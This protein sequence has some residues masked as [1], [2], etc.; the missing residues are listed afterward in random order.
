MRGA[1]AMTAT[2]LAVIGDVH[3]HTDHLNQVLERLEREPSLDGLL[4]VGDLGANLLHGRRVEPSRVVAYHQSVRDVLRRVE[5]FG[6]PFLW[7][8]GNHDARDLT[9]HRNV[10]RRRA[11]IGGLSVV[12]IGGAGPDIFGFPYEWGEAEIRGLSL[13]AADVL[14]SHAPPA[15]T[16]LDWVPRAG[17]H[18]GSEAIRERALAA[19]GFLVCGHIHESPGILQ[20]GACLVMN[21]GGLG[22]PYAH[23]RVGFIERSAAGDAAWIEDLISGAVIRRER[24]T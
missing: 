22:R 23:P 18:V 9:G 17:K 7:V 21:V 20:L 12:G 16:P 24:A 11:R 5:D 10:D 3:A 4:L 19:R 8:P 15:R 6:R 1:V 14:L 13:P 2:R